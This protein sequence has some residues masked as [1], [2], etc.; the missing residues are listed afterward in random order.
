MFWWEHKNF[1][2]YY[3]VTVP[4]HSELIPRL[5]QIACH[6][7]HSR[8]AESGAQC[9][10]GIINK[11]PEGTVSLVMLWILTTVMNNQSVS[12]S[13]LFGGRLSL[14]KRFLIAAFCFQWMSELARDQTNVWLTDST[15]ERNIKENYQVK[16]RKKK[17][18]RIRNDRI[19]ELNMNAQTS[20]WK[21]ESELM[22]YTFYSQVLL[23]LGD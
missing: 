5:Q 2:W 16:Q 8:S 18:R 15:Q 6:C 23:F 9:L 12:C 11:L 7:D 22:E 3:Q 17:R 21:I 20:E 10:A 13:L 4:R 14:L 19:I 1:C